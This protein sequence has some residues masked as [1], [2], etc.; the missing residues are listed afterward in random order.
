[1]ADEVSVNYSF[2]KVDNFRLFWRQNRTGILDR[3]SAEIDL[4]KGCRTGEFC[5]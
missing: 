5:W 3:F 2:T 4:M 1:M